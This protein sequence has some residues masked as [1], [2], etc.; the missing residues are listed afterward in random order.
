[1]LA[2]ALDVVD[3]D[4]FH[5]LPP[6]GPSSIVRGSS[7]RKSS[8]TSIRP[9]PAQPIGRIGHIARATN[10]NNKVTRPGVM[11]ADVRNA[12]TTAKPCSANASPTEAARLRPTGATRASLLTTSASP[13]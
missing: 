9:T 10:R 11:P 1:L 7:R 3:Q 13:A 12:C 4:D 5:G 2:D 8:H 6:S